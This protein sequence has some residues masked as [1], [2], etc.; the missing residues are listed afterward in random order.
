ME[1]KHPTRG[2]EIQVAVIKRSPVEHLRGVLENMLSLRA[3]KGSSLGAG[4]CRDEYLVTLAQVLE[5]DKM[6]QLEDFCL[7]YL[8][9]ELPP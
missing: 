9:S 1:A 8:Q 3:K 2:P 7:Q 5:S 6:Q 4:G